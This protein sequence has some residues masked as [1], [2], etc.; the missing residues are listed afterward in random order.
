MG[1][2][3][4]NLLVMNLNRYI[5]YRYLQVPT[6][7]SLGVL[8]LNLNCESERSKLFG[9][10]YK[11]LRRIGGGDQANLYLVLNI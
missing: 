10:Q 8:K 11:G 1:I 6:C 5:Q 2:D 7:S 9:L 3:E 4:G